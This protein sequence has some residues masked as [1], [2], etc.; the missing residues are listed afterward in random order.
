M[1]LNVNNEL[2]FIKRVIPRSSC[3]DE[4]IINKIKIN[5]KS[6]VYINSQNEVLFGDRVQDV[7]FEMIENSV[8]I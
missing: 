3:L 5:S 8:T 6:D 2:F 1:F 4:E 7:V